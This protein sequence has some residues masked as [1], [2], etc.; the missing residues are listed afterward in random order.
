MLYPRSLSIRR[1]GAHD[2]IEFL[3]YLLRRKKMTRHL[4]FERE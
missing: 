1:V 2:K 4:Y 3:S